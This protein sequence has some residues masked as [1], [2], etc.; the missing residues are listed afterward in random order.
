MNDARFSM[1]CLVL[2]TG[3]T[4][5]SFV[6]TEFSTFEGTFPFVAFLPLVVA[7]AAPRLLARDRAN[8]SVDAEVNADA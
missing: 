5:L 8:E 3:F 1:L 6:L 4:S 7:L 2:G